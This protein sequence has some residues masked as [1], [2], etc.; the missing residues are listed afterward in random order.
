LIELYGH[1]AAAD[2]AN[3]FDRL[4][5]LL[6]GPAAEEGYHFESLASDVLVALIRRYLADHRSIFEDLARRQKLVEVLELF[7]NAGSPEALKL[8]YELPDLLR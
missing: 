1:L 3:V 8:L 5:R 4:S 2:P 6:V 7:S